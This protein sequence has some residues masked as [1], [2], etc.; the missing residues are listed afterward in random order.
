MTPEKL[1][2]IGT[3][4]SGVGSCGRRDRVRQLKG[5][6]QIESDKS[7]TRITETLPAQSQS[8]WSGCARAYFA[9]SFPFF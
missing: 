9:F 3:K 7:G 4:G 2:E 1:E 8:S 5:K 6:M